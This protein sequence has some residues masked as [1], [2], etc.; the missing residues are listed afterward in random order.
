MFPMDDFARNF[1]A[2]EMTARSS[3]SDSAMNHEQTLV[4]EVQSAE[5]PV[6]PKVKMHADICEVL[7]NL[8]ERK[9]ADYGD[10]FAKS[11]AKFGMY[12]PCM[13][14]D[15]KL[16]RLVSLIEQKAQV[17]DE[18][19]EDTLLDIANYA[20]MTVIERNMRTLEK[21]TGK[22]VSENG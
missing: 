3:T 15:D 19:I 18:S 6:N 21:M 1:V 9:N 8:Y 5:C 17:K 7:N 13:R 11:Y 22:R 14:L 2:V 4:G 16:N 10:A 12:S 20:I